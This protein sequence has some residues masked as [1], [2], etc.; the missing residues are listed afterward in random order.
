[1]TRPGRITTIEPRLAVQLYDEMGSWHLVGK[2]LARRMGRRG[3]FQ[4]LSVYR[5]VHHYQ[6]K[7]SAD[8][9]RSTSNKGR[10]MMDQHAQIMATIAASSGRIGAYTL[11]IQVLLDAMNREAQLL[12]QQ[13]EALEW[14]NKS[15]AERDA[16]ILAQMAENRENRANSA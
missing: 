4:G 3:P 15:E 2:E 8:V 12:Q 7:V 10:E 13:R 14:I 16:A 1:M 5:T 6:K 9:L 11:S